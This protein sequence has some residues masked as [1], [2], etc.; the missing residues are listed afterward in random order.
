MSSWNRNS[1]TLPFVA[2]GRLLTQKTKDF[3]SI[4]LRGGIG[5]QLFQ[6]LAGLGYAERTGRQFVISEKYIS[7]NHHTSHQETQ[8][9][10]FKIFPTLKI[11]RGAVRWIV[12]QEEDGL[13]I[14]H[15]DGSVLLDGYFQNELYFSPATR[16]H[17]CFPKPAN[18]S[19][20]V[21][22]IH[23][24]NTYFIHF[25]YGDYLVSDFNVNLTNYY[26]TCVKLIRAHNS[27]AKFLL[28]SDQPHL[29]NLETCRLDSESVTIVPRSCGVLGSLY[30]M[31]L[32]KGAICAN[33][34]F[35]W[36][37]AFAI[38]GPGP[39]YMPNKW[40]NIFTH[41]PNPPWATVIDV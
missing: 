35:S 34:T 25:R 28:F 16:D 30:L 5:N 9:I 36:F 39:I 6:V 19:Y 37:G 3:V 23:F 40:H 32:C 4:K 33:S 31:A 18:F 12:Y 1:G 13:I 7:S 11:Y 20:D 14:P 22:T 27:T 38:R 29:I 41:V 24:D 2:P 26:Q 17:F 15:F 21:S 8:D 10:L